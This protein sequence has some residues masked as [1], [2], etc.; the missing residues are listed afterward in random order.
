MVLCGLLFTMT[1]A[2]AKIR[3]RYTENDSHSLDGM[4]YMLRATYDEHNINTDT[5]MTMQLEQDY[6]A[7]RWM[8]DHVAGSPVIVEG[9]VTEYK[10][11]GRYAINTGLP[12]VVGWNWH[13]RQQRAAANSE[14]V[15]QRVNEVNT[16]YSTADINAT[17]EFLRKYNVEYI[18]VGQMEKAIYPTAS[19]DKFEAYS[20]VYWT[21]VYTYKDTT[22]YEVIPQR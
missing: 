8:Q 2:S 14:W 15:Q 5:T 1:G 7:I 6:Q 19:L 11:G 22:I 21:P 16:F 3:D 17:V 13:Q 10:W 4:T 9:S 18:I 20:G 12:A